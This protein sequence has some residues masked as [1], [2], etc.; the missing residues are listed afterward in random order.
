Y[1]TNIIIVVLKASISCCTFSPFIVYTI[2]CKLIE[3]TL[4][5]I[6]VRKKAY[7]CSQ[8]WLACVVTFPALISLI[9]IPRTNCR[10]LSNGLRAKPEVCS[11]ILECLIRQPQFFQKPLLH[12]TFTEQSGSLV[13]IEQ[14]EINRSGL[15]LPN[16]ILVHF[17]GNDFTFLDRVT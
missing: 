7:H 1:H 6:I 15:L 14:Q 11:G 17:E 12:R 9:S 4:T 16:P 5:H 10:D 2:R 8:I 3:P 13:A